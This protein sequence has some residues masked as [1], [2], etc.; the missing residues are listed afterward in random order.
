ML[1][2][3]GTPTIGRVRLPASAFNLSTFGLPVSGSFGSFSHTMLPHKPPPHFAILM[4]DLP[5]SVSHV[6]V[7]SAEAALHSP[8]SAMV[9]AATR[10]MV[11]SKL[12]FKWARAPRAARNRRN[13][14]CRVCGVRATPASHCN[15]RA[16]CNLLAHQV[17][18]PDI[19][20]LAGA[21]KRHLV[22]HQDVRRDHQVGGAFGL[23]EGLEV[24]ALRSLLL[25]DQDQSFAFARVRHRGGSGQRVG[26]E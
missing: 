25:A 3:I 6:P 2:T 9:T 16:L 8:S 24:G 14:F 22:Y 1:I 13:R 15:R 17:G 4:C 21:E 19:V 5:P 18:D 10:R 11:M 23:G 20:E 12:P 7:G 26:P